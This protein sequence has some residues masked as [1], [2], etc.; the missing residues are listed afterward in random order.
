MLNNSK[1]VIESVKFAFDIWISN[2]F[3]SVLPIFIISS[4]LI[5]Y[6]FINITVFLFRP[7]MYLFGI[8]PNISFVF[9][10]SMLSG[11]PS[12]SKYIKELYKNN[13]INEDAANK[14]LMFTHFSNPLFIIGTISSLSNKKVAIFI[15][16]IHYITNIIIGILF[17][18][19]NNTY[20]KQINKLRSNNIS[21]DKAL[22]NSIKDAIETLLLI[23]GSISVCSFLSSIINHTFNFSNITSAII[24]GIIEITKGLKYVSLLNIPL[25]IK[26]TI[27][28]MFL[29]FGGISIHLQT[30]SILSDTNIKYTPYLI[31]RIIHTAISGILSFILFDLFM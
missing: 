23:L 25:K 16:I 3:P 28:V 30:K 18:N 6:G 15:L 24:S 8:N 10:M 7:L 12:S 21:F 4:L 17:R 13:L 31:S 9:I 27:S 19:Y 22:T 14:A 2:I 20:I 11:F 29:S 1:E 5:N 26:V